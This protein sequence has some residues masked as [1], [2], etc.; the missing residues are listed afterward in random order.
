MKPLKLFVSLMLFYCAG[1]FTVTGQVTPDL[2]RESLHG[3]KVN[4][5]GLRSVSQVREFYES[6][7]FRPA[8]ISNA[9]A[10]A[11][12][13][14]ILGSSADLGLDAADYQ[15]DLIHSLQQ[16]SVSKLKSLRLR[17]PKMII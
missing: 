10:C 17:C 2:I 12:L 3:S 15:Q 9:V 5:Y 11:Q 8:W 6:R 7:Q 13:L 4:S 14:L 1:A 16:H